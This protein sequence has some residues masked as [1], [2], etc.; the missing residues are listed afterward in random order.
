MNKVDV[1]VIQLRHRDCS[2][3]QHGRDAGAP[4]TGAVRGDNLYTL[5]TVFLVLSLTNRY[6]T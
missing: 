6:F 4:T 3:W 1:F 2:R 5:A